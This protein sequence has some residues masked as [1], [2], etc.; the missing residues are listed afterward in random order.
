MIRMCTRRQDFPARQPHRIRIGHGPYDDHQT[1]T[2]PDG[3][4]ERWRR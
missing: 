2:G 4:K 1:P 3:N